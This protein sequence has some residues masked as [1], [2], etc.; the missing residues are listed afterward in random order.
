MFLQ[1]A[2]SVVS[3][4]ASVGAV[5]YA[6]RAFR[7]TNRLSVLVGAAQTCQGY[8]G[9]VLELCEKGYTADEIRRLFDLQDS[10]HRQVMENDCGRVEDIVQVYRDSKAR[11]SSQ[12]N[13]ANRHLWQRIRPVS[14]DP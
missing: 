6:H 7:G 14:P 4:I 2:I 10:Y 1:N 3:A 8:Q 13:S 9:R 5:V 12:P 11:R